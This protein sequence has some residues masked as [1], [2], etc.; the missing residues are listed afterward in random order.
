MFID[1]LRCVL[2]AMRLIQRPHFI[3]KVVYCHPSPNE[4]SPGDLVIVMNGAKAKW[5][6]FLCP[7]G[8]GNR[9]QL[10]LNISARPSWRV[11][12][13]WLR[14]PTVYPSIR[15]L[16]ACQGHFWI[17]SGSVEWCPDSGHR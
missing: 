10:S 17:R 2:V 12:T 4:L 5:A 15:Q 14:R 11:S 3:Q 16:N 13:D 6:C 8:C 9:F 7:G 1:A